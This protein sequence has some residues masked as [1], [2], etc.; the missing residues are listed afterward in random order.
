[1]V[2]REPR[3]RPAWPKRALAV[4][5][6][7]A[8]SLMLFVAGPEI[9]LRLDADA[10]TTS[11]GAREIALDDGSVVHLAPGSAV[12][13]KFTAT[14]RSLSLLRGEAFLTIARD[15]ARPFVVRADGMAVTVTGTAFNVAF[16][17]R[18]YTVEVASGSV[19]VAAAGVEDVSLTSGQRLVVNRRTGRVT[20][21]AIPTKQVA[22]WR[23]G[24][25]VVENALLADVLDAIRRSHPGAILVTDTGLE[26][27]RVT[28]VYEIDR[29]ERALRALVGPFGGVVRA[30][31][32]YLLV[33]SEG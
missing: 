22:E 19:G 5:L 13:A 9:V 7:L 8:A 3:R 15:P 10:V 6:A 14:G 17:P 24:R 2:S 29:P 30:V 1:M 31:T 25:L 28:G 18:T 33:V 27:R 23:Y 12:A 20:I 21:R 4:T 32:P 11:R 26:D 16:T